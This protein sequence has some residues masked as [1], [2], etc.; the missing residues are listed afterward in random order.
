MSARQ[1]Y[2]YSERATWYKLPRT[3]DLTKL[4]DRW[5]NAIW[6]GKSDRSDEHIIG[7]ETG[8]VLARSVRRKVEGKRW[9]ERAPK[10]VTGTPRNPQPGEVVVRPKTLGGAASAPFAS[11]SPYLYNTP[12]FY[13]FTMGTNIGGGG[14]GGGKQ[15]HPKR[16]EESS[17]ATKKNEGTI[18]KRRGVEC[19][20]PRRSPEAASEGSTTQRRLRPST[21]SGVVLLSFLG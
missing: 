8:A 11:P 5:R 18:Q 14:G 12:P 20:T 2:R 16:R 9:N 19:N 21:F 13:Q 6:L 17:S 10:M 15:C 7:L 3:A 1:A 4:D